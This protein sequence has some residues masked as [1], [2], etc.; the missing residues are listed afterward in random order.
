MRGVQRAAVHAGGRGRNVVR[1]VPFIG[2]WPVLRR[3]AVR[4]LPLSV[5]VLMFGSACSDGNG[6]DVASLTSVTAESSV[7]AKSQEQVTEDAVS[8]LQEAG[9]PAS[10]SSLGGDVFSQSF[11]GEHIILLNSPDRHSY[12]GGGGE[13]PP[14]SQEDIE[15]FFDGRDTTDVY[16]LSV[17][18]VDRS[19]DFE[20]CMVQ[21]GYREPVDYESDPSYQKEVLDGAIRSGAASNQ[22]AACVREHGFP[23]VADIPLPTSY[24]DNMTPTVLLPAAIT[25]DQLRRLLDDCP[26]ISATDREALAADPAHEVSFPDIMFD[27]P[28]FDGKACTEYDSDPNPERPR[29]E[30][31]LQILWDDVRDL[32]EVPQGEGS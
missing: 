21:T 17:D 18:G 3:R 24:S 28:C 29:L 15:A 12:V 10:I 8:C 11:E 16:L 26:Q 19:E 5:G 27:A 31:L 22:W 32:Y 4:L 30:A 13:M 9:I 25:E 7:P 6:V 2:S 23:A 1:L 14:P 20:R